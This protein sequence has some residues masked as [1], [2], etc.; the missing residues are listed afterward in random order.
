MLDKLIPSGWNELLSGEFKKPYFKKLSESVEN[1]Y[2]ST[3]VFPKKDEIFTALKLTPP[4][5]V[6]CVIVGQDPYHE[7]NQAHG[8]A[9]SVLPTAKIPPSL[10]NIYK[11]L[12]D[13][14]GC[15]YP[16]NGFLR[17]WAE[18]GVLLLNA[19][20]TVQEGKAGSHAKFGWQA[21]TD[22][23]I[24]AVSENSAHRVCFML[25]GNFAIKKAELIDVNRHVILTAAHPSPLSASRGFFGCRHFSKANEI[26]AANKM[27]KINWQI[28]LL[29][30]GR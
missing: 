16:D 11:E 15:F 22:S 28:P 29:Y 25:W 24:S 18:Q 13:D 17:P 4:E 26:I 27:E 1:A 23:I 8:L 9:F 2:E 7:V 3:A 30:G 10:R 12:C 21:L 6:K 20:L 14:E 5:K 19:C